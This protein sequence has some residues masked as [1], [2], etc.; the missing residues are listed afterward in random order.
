MQRPWIVGGILNPLRLESDIHLAGETGVER[1]KGHEFA[2]RPM[3]TK[4]MFPDKLPCLHDLLV[5]SK[6]KKDGMA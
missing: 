5:Q 3:P 4:P 1:G 6:S 2:M